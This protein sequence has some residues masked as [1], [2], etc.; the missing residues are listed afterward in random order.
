MRS[1]AGQCSG[2]RASDELLWGYEFAGLEF[3]LDASELRHSKPDGAELDTVELSV[4]LGGRCL[5]KGSYDD[6]FTSLNINIVIYG[7]SKDAEL[8]TDAWH[9]DR[10]QGGDSPFEHPEYHF[11]QGGKKIWEVQTFDYGS[12]LLLESPRLDHKPLDGILAV[13]FVLANFAGRAWQALKTDNPSYADLVREAEK[14][15]HLAYAQAA[16]DYLKR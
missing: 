1:A 10:H 9:L 13:N 6:P 3:T 16:L 4:L 5:D 15:C 11:H 14:R 12:Y 2:N 7:L 8:L